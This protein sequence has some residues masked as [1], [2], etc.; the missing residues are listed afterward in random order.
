[1]TETEGKMVCSESFT[2]PAVGGS[3]LAFPP[4]LLQGSMAGI[5]LLLNCCRRGVLFGGTVMTEENSLCEDGV[6]Q[7]VLG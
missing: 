4:S 2:F 3:G 5:C 7:T 6:G 1:M